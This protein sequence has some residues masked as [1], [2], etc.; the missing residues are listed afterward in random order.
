MEGGGVKGIAYLGAMEVLEQKGI[1]GQIKRVGGT[2]AGAIN[3]LLLGLGYSNNET[4]E[5]LWQLDFR[6]FKDESFGF[7]TDSIRL[8]REYGWFKGDYFR[9]LIAELVKTKTG[10]PNATFAEIKSAGKF[11][12]IYFI[13]SNLSTRLEAIF[14]YEHTPD[15]A[16]ADA[17]RISVSIPLFFAAKKYNGHLFVDGGLLD[18]YPIKLFDRKKYAENP[19]SYRETDYYT[20]Q[21]TILKS[22]RETNWFIYNKETL[23]FRLD[24]AREISVFAGSEPQKHDI[25]N[26]FSY[27]W[28][29]ISTLL[30]NQESYHLHSDDW[31]RTIY[32]DTIG[33]RTTQFDISDELKAGLIE[34]GR[35][36]TL[37]YF[38]WYDNDLTAA[39]R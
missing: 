22:E 36:S 13:G 20:A 19:S 6:K 3:A 23:G 24:S 27:T 17:V 33:V 2:S 8:F 26:F 21:N 31:Q 14:S 34:S 9:N 38:E 28:A 15:I 32:I 39:N 4:K 25:K 10:N 37:K 18:N 7:I 5:I 35:I 16:V 1:L 30:E 29:L 11:R 12:D